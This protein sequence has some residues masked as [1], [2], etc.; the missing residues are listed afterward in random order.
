MSG[1]PAGRIAAID[2]LRGLTIL[3]MV[4]CAQIGWDSGLPGWMFHAQL[5]PPDYKFSP[6]VPGITWVDLVFPFFLFSMG[7]AFPFSLR[8]KLERGES[9]GQVVSGLVKR[10]I[11]LLLFSIVLGNGQ[12]INSAE[13][14]TVVKSLLLLAV[15]SG[16]FLSLTRF[17]TG[18]SRTAALLN[19]SGV[20]LLIILAV[21]EASLFD[22]EFSVNRVN[23]IITVLANIALFGGLVWLLTKDRPVWRWGIWA[24]VIAIKALSMYTDLLDWV[25]SFGTK[26]FAFDYLK[27]L[28]IAIPGSIVGDMLMKDRPAA[29]GRN[30]AAG[31]P[32]TRTSAG[33]VQA[34]GKMRETAAAV[35]VVCAVVLQLWGLYTRQVAADFAISAALAAAVFLLTLKDRP[36]WGRIACIGFVL[37]LAGIAADPLEGGIR[38]DPCN[39]SY[40]L[41]AGGMAAM[42]TGV[43]LFFEHCYGFKG[44]ILAGCGQNPMIAYTATAFLINPLLSLAGLMEPLDSLTPGSPF[45]GL[46]RGVLITAAVALVTNMF[47]HF[48]IYW[49]S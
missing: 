24:I 10:W 31:C 6:D 13:T 46:M 39:I 3:G 36:L 23:I 12:L 20:G 38:K 34:C 25:P 11:I 37:M 41:A 7:A 1:Q 40:L 4:L 28:G 43:F 48:K 17:R 8:K 47:T 2:I 32:E 14:G 44:R 45:W 26:L 49:R 21:L 9:A 42:T 16:M 15:W 35:L 22:V 19:I 27:Y 30:G 33:T 18:K 29:S 5:P